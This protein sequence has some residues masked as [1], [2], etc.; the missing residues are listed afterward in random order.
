MRRFLELFCEVTPLGTRAIMPG[1][2]S[3]TPPLSCWQ[4]DWSYRG[5]LS[6]AGLSAAQQN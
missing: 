5:S 2:T 4:C 1:S 3:W 6:G